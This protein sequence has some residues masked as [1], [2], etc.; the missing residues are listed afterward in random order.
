MN[1]EKHEVFQPEIKVKKI[2]IENFRGFEQL[3]LEFQPD[4]TVFCMRK[5][6]RKNHA[7]RLLC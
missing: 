3:E 5:W 1:Q 7:F 4:L 6:G 2:A